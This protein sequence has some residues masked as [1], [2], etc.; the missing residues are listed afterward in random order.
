MAGGRV[1]STA[2]SRFFRSVR[3]PPARAK[4]GGVGRLFQASAPHRTYTFF[5]LSDLGPPD[6]NR[7]FKYIYSGILFISLFSISPFPLARSKREVLVGGRV[8]STT[9]CAF[10]T[11]SGHPGQSETRTHIF[12]MCF[13]FSLGRI[14]PRPIETRGSERFFSQQSPVFFP[15]FSLRL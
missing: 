13:L 5:A 7:R 3:F 14:R 10:F 2:V 9:C 4:Q 11:L 1:A 6:R 8:A 15:L 12:T